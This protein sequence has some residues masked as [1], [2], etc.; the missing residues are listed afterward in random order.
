MR[1]LDSQ[2][3]LSIGWGLFVFLEGYCPAAMN[4]GLLSGRCLRFGV[5]WC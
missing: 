3:R 1:H 4:W 5:Q 2:W